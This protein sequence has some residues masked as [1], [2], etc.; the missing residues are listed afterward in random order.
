MYLSVPE[1]NPSCRDFV[2]FGGGT[3]VHIRR[4]PTTPGVGAFMR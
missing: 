4:Y 3:F 1:Q 2:V